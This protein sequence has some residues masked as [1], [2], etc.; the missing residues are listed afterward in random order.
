MKI[1]KL[2]K[3]KSSLNER[4]SDNPTLNENLCHSKLSF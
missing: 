2:P 3:R 1:L 4:A